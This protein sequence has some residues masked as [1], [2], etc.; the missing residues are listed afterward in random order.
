[1]SMELFHRN[2]AFTLFHADQMPL[3]QAGETS[4]ESLGGGVHRVRVEFRNDRLIP[5]ITVR[6]RQNRVVR[7][8]IVSVEGNVEVIAAG[9]VNDLSRSA[10]LQ[11]IDQEELDRIRV[12]SGAPGRTPRTLEYL[13]RGS[14]R[15]TIEYASLKGGTVSATVVLP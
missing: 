8:D 13:V 10:P 3:M 11:R 2:M 4:V 15:M 9:W 1:M 14:G 7:P 6:A 12:R 5:T